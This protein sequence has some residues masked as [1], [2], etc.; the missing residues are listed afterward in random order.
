[1]T[2]PL[3]RFSGG[4][5][6]RYVARYKFKMLEPLTWHDPVYGELTAPTGF[7]SDLASVRILREIA[8]WMLL[9]AVICACVPSLAVRC[10]AVACFVVGF[11]AMGL[12]ALVVG[13]CMQAAIIHDW[14]YQTKTLPRRSSDAVLYRA[15]HIG[16]GTAAW[17][18]ALFWVG[19]RVCG[20]PHYGTPG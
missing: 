12:Y 9:L 14:L 4:A 6:T 11:V 19:V 15:G 7:V 10:F 1:M 16:E 17:R 8:A 2:T 20:A 3:G 18:A 5:A 13:Y